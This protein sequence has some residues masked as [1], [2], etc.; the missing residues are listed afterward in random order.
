MHELENK[1]VLDKAL[2]GEDFRELKRQ[3]EVD[4]APG[5]LLPEQVE[6][7]HRVATAMETALEDNA[8]PEFSP[9]L[10]PMQRTAL[11]ALYMAKT[12]KH[13]ETGEFVSGL[14]RNDLLNQ[15]L[16]YL[17]PILALGLRMDFKEGRPRYDQMVGKVSQVKAEITSAIRSQIMRRPRK[18]KPKKKDGEDPTTPRDAGA[19]AQALEESSDE[20]MASEAASQEEHT[21]QEEQA[22]QEERASQEEQAS[23]EGADGAERGIP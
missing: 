22:S 5:K 19:D 17:Q 1:R 10:A 23:Q 15:A 11:E 18:K 13:I 21:S 6:E 20:E 7:F 9:E 8:K 12:A 16:I 14:K 2:K 4:A 3:D